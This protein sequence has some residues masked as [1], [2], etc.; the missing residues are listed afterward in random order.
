MKQRKTR[1]SHRTRTPGLFRLDKSRIYPDGAWEVRYR[2]GDNNTRRKTFRTKPEALD[3]QSSVRTDKHRGEFISPRR[4]ETLLRAV[5]EDWFATTA[6]LK[7]KTRAGYRSILDYHVLPELGSYPV[8][9]VTPAVIKRFLTGREV[10]P[11]TQ[12]NILRVLSPI[13]AHAVDD[14]MIR[15]N[16]C[17]RV[18]L[19]KATRQEMLFLTADEI[20]TLADAITPQYRTLVYFAAYTGLRSGEIAALRMKNLGPDA[21][22]V[23][24]EGSVADVN[25]KLHFGPPKNGR[26]RTVSLPR[27]LGEL[28]T[29]QVA[30]KDPDDY[31]FGATRGGPLRHGNFYARHF[32]P[33]V[34]LALPAHLQGLRFHDLR[35][36]AAS[37]L[38]AQGRHPKA[39]AER[40]GHSS[41]AI[42]M[43][44]YGHLY[45]DQDEKLAAGLDEMFAR[46]AGDPVEASVVPIR[47]KS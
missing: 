25:G 41:I 19:P 22:R 29:K 7:P 30:G 28:L 35:H 16:P 12:R 24:V 13:L 43:D 2:D 23:T 5:A 9:R 27:F 14:E 26:V 3:F 38:I 39:I 42:T 21:R 10:G 17:A 8:G 15:A 37:L 18:K 36:T 20:A 47:K 33:T 1:R 44:R 40:L 6:D 4:A 11:G 45:P 32:K 46:A 31:V 34:Q